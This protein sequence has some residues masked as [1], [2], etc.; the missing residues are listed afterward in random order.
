MRMPSRLLAVSV[1]LALGGFALSGCTSDKKGPTTSPPSSTSSV[2]PSAS[3]S[4]SA[5]PAASSSPSVS[6]PAEARQ[7]TPEGA[8]AFVKFYFDQ[9]NKAYMT[10]DATLLPPLGEPGC[11]SCASLQANAVEYVSLGHRFANPGVEL[12]EV[13]AVD[14]GEPGQQMVVFKMHQ[15]AA[16]VVDA[17]NAVVST[18]VDKMFDRKALVAWQGFRWSIVAIG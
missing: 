6:I 11:K 13:T 12:Q 8:V 7:N 14:G 17:N 9:A 15:L 16:N 10:P 4:E 3:A 18:E 5:S 1:A 2:S